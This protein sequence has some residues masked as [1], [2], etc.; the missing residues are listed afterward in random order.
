MAPKAAAS[1]VPD[2]PAL[3]HCSSQPRQCAPRALLPCR[4]LFEPELKRTLHG[5]TRGFCVPSPPL[6]RAGPWRLLQIFR[7]ELA[8]RR[9]AAS[10]GSTAHSPLPSPVPRA[11]RRWACGVDHNCQYEFFF[12]KRTNGR[13]SLIL[14]AADR[15]DVPFDLD[16]IETLTGRF[17]KRAPRRSP[18]SPRS[19][20]PL[21]VLRGPRLMRTT[22]SAPAP[23]LPWQG[24]TTTRTM[25]PS[26]TRPSAAP[27]YARATGCTLALSV[28]PVF[29]HVHA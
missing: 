15:N 8:A 12:C 16:R 18:A 28:A 11:I 22:A 20:S 19:L 9:L 24:C 14:M 29:A 10:V 27:P 2:A 7:T 17:C 4:L 1:S 23:I 26:S 6:A 13:A 21:F 5:L 25:C 3:G